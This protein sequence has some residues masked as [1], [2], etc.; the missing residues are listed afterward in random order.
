ME[1]T[2]NF[3]L[4]D[5]STYSYFQERRRSATS[6]PNEPLTSNRNNHVDI[7]RNVASVTPDFVPRSPISLEEDR[8]NERLVHA[9]K[10]LLAAR[11][12]VL[13]LS[14]QRVR[15]FFFFSRPLFHNSSCF[16][17][18]ALS[19]VISDLAST[20]IITSIDLN[21]IIAHN[22]T[23]AH[24]LLVGLLTNANPDNNNPRPFLDILPFLPPTLPTFDLYGR[25]LRDQT[26][27]TVQGYSTVADLVLMEIL[28]CFVHECINWLE[29][30]EK[31]EKAGN[32][33]D[34]RFGKGVQNVRPPFF[35]SYTFL[36]GFFFKK[37]KPPPLPT[38]FFFPPSFILPHPSFSY[39][40]FITHSSNYRSWTR[41]AMQILLKWRISVFVMLVL[42]K[43]IR[44]TGSLPLPDS[45]R[46]GEI[47]FFLDATQSTL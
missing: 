8:Q 45:E 13:T 19:P 32:I 6:D 31:E 16:C 47:L 43:R 26:R 29:N 21:A 40:D 15:V 20:N 22:P 28:G 14:E 4:R 9:V 39:V 23:I 37:K 41:H 24:P 36:D 44:F 34:D 12:R 5:D 25:L 1:L 33:S 3:Q 42:K 30:A 7:R 38:F 27:V 11:D 2:S 18:Q 10:L 17:V 46:G 35:F